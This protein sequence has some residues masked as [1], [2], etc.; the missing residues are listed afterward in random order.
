MTPLIVGVA[1]LIIAGFIA[2]S[3][4]AYAV[5]AR[6]IRPDKPFG[7]AVPAWVSLLLLGSLGLVIYGM[8]KLFV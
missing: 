7:G 2:K 3:Y 4:R 6:R 5:V 1:G 8:I